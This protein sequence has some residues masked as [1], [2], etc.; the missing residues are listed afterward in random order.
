MI[1]IDIPSVDPVQ[2]E[3]K[4]ILGMTT[5]QIFCAVPC[6]IVGATLFAMLKDTSMDLA[7][8]SLMTTVIPGALFGWYKPYNMKFEQ[9]LK[10]A[11][12]NNFVNN[13]R[14]VYK[15]DGEEEIKWNNIK[16]QREL[17]QKN[18]KLSKNKKNDGEE[19]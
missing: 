1:E 8:V 15:T 7:I 3:V 13:P 16:N 2:H 11:I 4:V 18:K 9:F 17:N 6:A 10:L 19:R 14:R 12:D 5:R